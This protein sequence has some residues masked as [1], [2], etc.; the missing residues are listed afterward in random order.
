MTYAELT[1]EVKRTANVLQD[2]GVGQGD[3]VAI[4]L[5]MIPEAVI[6]CSRWRAS[7][8][9]TRWCS[10]ASAPTACAR[11]STTPEPSS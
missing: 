1:D 10:A 4:Y 8:R 11:A 9:C 5:P 2:L 6:R 7:A 3:R